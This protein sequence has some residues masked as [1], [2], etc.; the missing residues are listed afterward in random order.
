MIGSD[1]AVVGSQ[2]QKEIEDMTVEAPDQDRSVRAGMG[3]KNG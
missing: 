3:A 2:A 1:M